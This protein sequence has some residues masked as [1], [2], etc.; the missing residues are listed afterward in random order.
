MTSQD[1]IKVEHVRT[2]L[3][4]LF[5]QSSNSFDLNAFFQDLF[6]LILTIYEVFFQL[7]VSGSLCSSGFFWRV[8][9]NVPVLFFHLKS[10]NCFPVKTQV[11]GRSFVFSTFCLWWWGFEFAPAR[12]SSVS[13]G[14][15]VMTSQDYIKVEHVRTRLLSSSLA[16]FQQFWSERFFS[17]FIYFN[18]NYLRS[19][20]S[21]DGFRSLVFQWVFFE[22]SRIMFL[23]FFFHLKSS[24]C[25]PVK[26]Q[27]FG[28]S[29][30]FS[31]FCL[32][33]WGFEF[34]P[35]RGSSVSVGDHVMTSQDYIKVEHVRTRL[36]SSSLAK[37]QQFWSERFFS[38]F[39]YFNS[40]YLRS[41]FSVDGFRFLVFQWVLL[42]S[43]E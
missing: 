17:R 24:N 23:F 27:V 20:F 6:T 10:S 15:H 3:L 35:A 12:G 4:A 25:F 7:T 30:V 14:D 29:F 9:N 5:L 43:R 21:V 26:T 39:I 42:K 1:Y 28:R 2:W 41:L 19:L 22:K 37:F 33:W 36:L 32:W 8:E 13:V 34:A 11:F 18:S 16:K 40:N 38:R 31:T